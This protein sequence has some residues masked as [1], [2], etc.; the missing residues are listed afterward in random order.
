[1]KLNL[2]SIW[3]F[4]TGFKNHAIN[5][6]QEC[7]ENETI[8]P[9][10]TPVTDGMTTMPNVRT[11]SDLF[12]QYSKCCVVGTKVTIVATPVANTLDNQLGYLYAIK[13]SQPNTALS[14]TS[15]V[16]DINKMPYRKM[17]KIQGA[18]APT[19]GFQQGNITSAKLVVNHSPKKFNNIKDY[20]DNPNLFNATGSNT[21][22]SKP[23]E[24][25]YLTIGVIPSLNSRDEQVTKFALQVRIEQKLL[26]T[27]ALEALA[28]NDGQGGNYSFPWAAGAAAAG[29]YALGM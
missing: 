18:M 14:N 4:D 28:T 2:N 25:D 23:S 15:T 8:T 12:K 6:G 11:G 16:V 9:Y 26:W 27:E 24:S 17:A 20:R 13:H 1:L 3:P 22:A 7:V 19:S 29:L 10:A 21:G 5:A